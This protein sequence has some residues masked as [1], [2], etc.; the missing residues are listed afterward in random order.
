MFSA[1][2]I[3]LL[4]VILRDTLIFLIILFAALFVW[5]KSGINVDHLSFNHYEV[6]GL[7]I[8]LD[9]KLTL[10]ANTI[11]I[12]KS[13][14]KPS[15]DNID[16]V[17]DRVKYLLT[18]FHYIELE[19]VTFKDNHYKMVYADNILYITS[20]DYE[21][22]GNV[23][24]RGKV[25][26]ADISLFYIKK[27]NI[28]MVAKFNYD[29]H[30][31]KLILEG[32]YDAYHIKGKFKAIKEEHEVE[33]VVNSDTFSDLKTF[34]D[35]IPMKKKLNAWIT[36]KI[37]AREYR[38]YSLR[39]KGTVHG[40]EFKPDLDSL[41]GN[42]L[43]ED[44]NIHYKE[45][46]SPVKAENILLRYES[47][48]LFFNVKKPTYQNREINASSV[49]ISNI[50]KGKIARLD[51]DMHFNTKVDE[52]VQEILKAYKLNIPVLHKESRSKVEVKL[53]IP[54]KKMPKRK[55]DVFVQASLGKGNLYIQ[56]L[57][58]PVINGNI[59]Y[60]KGLLK[61]KDIKLKEKWYEGTVNGK[62]KVREKM[63]D[64]VFQAK[65][66]ELKKK[67][68]TLFFMTD[69]KIPFYLNYTKGVRITIPSLKTKVIKEGKKVKIEIEDIAKIKPYL[70]KME[71]DV[72]GGTMT[73]TTNDFN[74]YAFTGKLY[75]KDCFIY[76]N[77]V[78]Y[79]MVPCFGTS[80]PKGVD[81]YAF[82]KR[83]HFNS[84]KS[85]IEL[86][87][88]NI[89]L[90]KFLSSDI[91]IQKIKTKKAK[92]SKT[93]IKGRKSNI[94][95]DKYTLLTDKYNVSIFSPSG[96][97]KAS[98]NLGKDVVTFKKRGKK[99]SIEALRIHD[100]MLHPLINFDGLQNGRYTIKISG[101]PN[102]LM[103]GEILLKGGVLKSFKAY[104]K[105][106]NFIRNNKDLAQIQDPGF[107]AKGFKIREGKITYRGVKNRV[108]FD[109]VYIRGDT[110]TIVGK[111][112]LDI[113]TKKLNINLAIQ[114]V[115]KIGKIVGSLP[116]LGYILMGEDNSITF[117]L[118]ITGTLD[119][120]K[121]KTSAVK[122]ILMLPF[123]LIKRTLQS[124]AHIINTEKTKKKVP[125]I[126]EITI[127][128]D[129]V[130]P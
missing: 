65:K 91:R 12:P 88:L 26:I 78:C 14:K 84:A 41:K 86:N 115:R 103:K 16:Q 20:D 98:G 18:F 111:G 49:I 72:D 128:K 67:K 63:A 109:S 24:R 110:A 101:D 1:H 68:E 27:E 85:L 15:F 62:V 83:L 2:A 9:K 107:T 38:L 66:I 40:S 81:F 17:L 94:R 70:K 100:R 119:D 7:Y 21:I 125:V 11:T 52:V 120:P 105:A 80:G 116:V 4:H 45:G 44:V 53:G 82:N 90:Q 126:E 22:A 47:G 25:L 76:D 8:K 43:L 10:K 79:T 60:E 58:L 57:K 55:I 89:D 77:K 48:E 31:D 3:H 129:R 5:L 71:I 95:Y 113:N 32:S 19:E 124:P 123:D 130:A 117:G 36:E 97:I 54:L 46:L 30:T 59:I 92:A 42:A 99:I 13:K 64:L 118:K 37:K 35:K 93:V 50:G 122:E 39:G 56:K 34:I 28:N 6:D 104:N 61:L 112:E 74:T 33:F 114:T 121:V 87:T 108:I 75:R 102:K 69:K 51:L 29:L 23:W 96:T 127:P 106:R 73:V